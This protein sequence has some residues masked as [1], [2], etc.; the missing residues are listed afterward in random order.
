MISRR[1]NISIPPDPAA[2]RNPDL[3]PFRGEIFFP[4]SVL[5]YRHPARRPHEEKLRKR[6]Y[7]PIQV[8]ERP[9]CER[10]LRQMRQ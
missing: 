2:R 6:I 4:H 1:N 9:A 7:N 10:A 5:P 3:T 8:S